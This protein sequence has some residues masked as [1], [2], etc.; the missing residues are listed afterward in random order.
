MESIRISRFLMALGA[1]LI[2]LLA[3]C[4]PAARTATPDGAALVAGETSH[5]SGQRVIHRETGVPVS[6]FFAAPGSVQD[7]VNRGDVVFTG[8]ISEVG[9]AVWEKA[10]DWEPADDAVSTRAGMPPFRINATYHRIQPDQVFLD[11]GNL[12]DYPFLRLISY[13]PLPWPQAGERY[14]FVL[15]ANPDGKSYGMA[16]GWHLIPLD[17]G[18]IRDFDGNST[19]YVGVTD[20]TSLI[21]AIR[22]AVKNRVHLPVSQWP[23]RQ[24]WLSNEEDDSRQDPPAPGGDDTDTTGPVGKTN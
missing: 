21:S 8:A 12:R 14:L 7:L 17:G 16:A 15:N 13:E 4:Q 22:E 20:E 9:D 6:A 5:N 18:D 2:I 23:V 1:I 10:Y 19:S 3:A 11:D 24:H